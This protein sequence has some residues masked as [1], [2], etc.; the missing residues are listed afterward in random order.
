MKSLSWEYSVNYV[1]LLGR[2]KM[3]AVEPTSCT[4]IERSHSGA[5]LNSDFFP[6]NRNL[7]SILIITA[8]FQVLTAMFLKIPLPGI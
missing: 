8:K 3:A 1:Y 6:L 2:V 7:L 4:A 5:M